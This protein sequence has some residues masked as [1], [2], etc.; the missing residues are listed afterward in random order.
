M[1][2]SVEADPGSLLLQQQYTYR[3]RQIFRELDGHG[4]VKNTE[5]KLWDVLSLGG[6]EYQ[7]LLEEKGKPLPPDKEQREQKKLDKEA[8]EASRLTP[9]K[10]AEREQ[11]NRKEREHDREELRRIP[12][13]FDFTLRGVSVIDGRENWI[14]GC[15]PRQSYKG[16]Y[17]NFLKHVRGVLYIDKQDYFWAKIECEVLD[18]VSIG[19]FLAKLTKGSRITVEETRINN[20]VW[21][22]R[23]VRIRAG[24]RLLVK[25]FN[26]E[27]EDTFSDYRKYSTDSRVL[28]TSEDGH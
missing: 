10:R 27:E 14:I 4:T 8:A 21:L 5:D 3:R 25:H 23:R 9:Q 19:L 2:R 28:E 20:E 15:E 12:D 18:D 1:V 7:R 24:A 11:E 22:P 26:I 6:K 17:D 13:A 16:K